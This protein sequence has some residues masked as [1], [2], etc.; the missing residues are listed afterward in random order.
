VTG[1]DPVPLIYLVAGEPSGDV[2]GAGLIAAL[3]ELC[4]GRI[5][6]SGIGGSRMVAEGFDSLFP[7]AELSIMGGAEI[8]PHV[9]RLLKRIRQTVAN[10]RAMRPDVLVTI[11]SPGFCFRVAKRLQGEG[12]PLVH[13]VAPTVWAWKPRRARKISRFLDHLLVLLPFE[14]PY[15]EVENLDCTFVGHPV[16][17]SGA[18]AGDGDGFRRRHDIAPGTPVLCVLPGSRRSETGRLLPVFAETVARLKLGRPD[19]TVVVPTVETVADDVAA[20]TARWPVPAIVVTGETEKYDAFAAADAA[21]AASGTVALELALAKV[22]SVI[23][24]RLNPISGWLAR[25]LVRVRFV[26]LVNLVLDKQAV[27]EFLQDDCRP[28]R[29]AAALE[30]LLDDENS[31]AEQI[32]AMIKAL[33]RLGLGGPSPSV[34]AAEVV[35]N[36]IADRRTAHSDERS[37]ERTAK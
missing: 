37:P 7:M 23:A 15:F 34:R 29:L 17:D 36:L 20:A 5:R 24:Y 22:P 18:D 12:I 33:E 13:Y 2:L 26:N 25:R 9:P 3:K 8:L 35:H 31:R 4:D 21:L 6:F 14:P 11:D 1:D 30:R 28:D 10:I 27:P 32:D 19:L 16:M